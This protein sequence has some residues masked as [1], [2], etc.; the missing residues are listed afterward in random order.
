MKQVRSPSSGLHT[1]CCSIQV[2]VR[3]L[4][5]ALFLIVTKNSINFFIRKNETEF[6]QV[7]SVK[8]CIKRT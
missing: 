6:L 4:Q 3:R 1:K 7:P 2:Y 5:L 8:L